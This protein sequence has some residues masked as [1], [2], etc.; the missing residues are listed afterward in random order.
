VVGFLSEDIHDTDEMVE[1][2]TNAIRETELVEPGGR[3]VITAG[4]PFGMRGTTNLIRVERYR[5]E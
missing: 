3:F 2:A 4:V 1:F 5:P